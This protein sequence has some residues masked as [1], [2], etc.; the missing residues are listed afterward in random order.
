MKTNAKKKFIFYSISH[1]SPDFLYSFFFL[2]L[3]PKTSLSL[4]SLSLSIL[5]ME[6]KLK[7]K[8]L[9]DPWERPTT[10]ETHHDGDLS[11]QIHN[12]P[13][14]LISLLLENLGFFFFFLKFVGRFRQLWLW[15]VVVYVI[16]D[17]YGFV[18]GRW[19][20]LVGFILSC[21]GCHGCWLVA[22]VSSHSCLLDVFCFR[23]SF[24]LILF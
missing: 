21:G 5:A 9:G 19:L 15:F 24:E 10:T 18:V 8:V 4:S 2:G 20:D 3:R 22:T 11:P 1:F 6:I 12:H 16:I 13:S 14:L 7:L 23:Q 17:G